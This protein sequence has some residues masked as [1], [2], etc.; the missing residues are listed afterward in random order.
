[1]GHFVAK[2]HRVLADDLAGFVVAGRRE[3]FVVEASPRERQDID[4]AGIEQQ[5]AVGGHGATQHDAADAEVG[6]IDSDGIAEGFVVA[7]IASRGGDE[8]VDPSFL[9][10]IDDDGV[11]AAGCGF[12][13]VSQGEVQ[14][15]FGQVAVGGE[16][17]D[18]GLKCVGRQRRD[19]AP[20]R[21]SDRGRALR[22][23]QWRGSVDDRVFQ[24]AEHLAEAFLFLVVQ[25][26]GDGEFS[27]REVAARHAECGCED[28]RPVA[29][30]QSIGESGAGG[31]VTFEG[32]IAEDQQRLRVGESFAG[33][34]AIRT[35]DGEG[36]AGDVGDEHEFFAAV[37]LDLV[38]DA[39][40]FAVGDIEA[41]VVGRR[42][43]GI[44][45]GIVDRVFVGQQVVFEPFVEGRSGGAGRVAEVVEKRGFVGADDADNV[46]DVLCDF[47]Q[48]AAGG[49]GGFSGKAHGGV[50]S[51]GGVGGGGPGWGGRL[52]QVSGLG[53]LCELAA[54][55]EILG[56]VAAV[57]AGGS[58]L[59]DVGELGFA[60]RGG[61]A[62]RAGHRGHRRGDRIGLGGRPEEG[63]FQ[64]EGFD[65]TG[66]LLAAGAFGEI[67][68]FGQE[69]R[70]GFHI[71]SARFQEHPFGGGA[72]LHF[73]ESRVGFI[74]LGFGEGELFDAAIELFLQRAEL[75]IR[76]GCW[77]RRGRIGHG[78]ILG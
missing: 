32:G 49:V 31:F 42:G 60:S 64:Q 58:A 37:G 14:L 18:V 56:D 68:A 8:A 21:A 59:R 22:A 25:L 36:I 55:A 38:A 4:A 72:G 34:R 20:H 45:G 54:K 66:E 52:A 35:A 3:G 9:V 5:D 6:L 33:R 17:V 77:G 63:F 47:G 30:S 71:R 51:I 13:D 57:A 69:K 19:N 7:G 41:R 16:A 24:V 46:G 12:P 1:M 29:E 10:A 43:G 62:W 76:L 53:S 44:D 65:H 11:D 73:R 61:V 40:A 39:E 23:C 27:H 48:R 74:A 28:L 15:R 70:R 67:D 26:V 78:G 75:V 50:L 2:F